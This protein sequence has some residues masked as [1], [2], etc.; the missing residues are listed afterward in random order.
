M[1]M[2][3]PGFSTMDDGETEYRSEAPGR[4]VPSTVAP[5]LLVTL[6]VWTYVC[7]THP[8]APAHLGSS[9]PFSR[10]RYEELKIMGCEEIIS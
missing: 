4:K 5:K 7:V 1:S 9:L 2:L 10:L 8:Q 3:F 6:M